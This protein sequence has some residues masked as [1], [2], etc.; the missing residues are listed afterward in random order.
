MSTLRLDTLTRWMKPDVGRDAR[1]AF[2]A[3]FVRF[4]RDQAR[5]ERPFDLKW[6]DRFACLNDRTKAMKFDRHYLLHTGWAARQV[7]TLRP[8]EHH[9]FSSRDFFAAIVSAFVPVRFYEFR[10][11]QVSLPGLHTGFADLTKLDLPDGSVASASCMH[12]IEHLGL[13]RYGDPIDAEGDLKAAAELTRILAPGGTL[14]IV[15]PVGRSRIVFNAHRVYSHRQV[16]EMFAPL[17][18]RTWALIPDRAEDGD[19]VEW[20]GEAMI[21]A[22]TYG[23]GCYCFERPQS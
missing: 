10:P 14:L 17:R 19:V 6:D 9:D 23:C 13:G 2:E 4:A 5:S 1:E 22:Q 21:D 8:V 15:T 11:P 3:D 18:L 16:L 20:A 7:A 12:V